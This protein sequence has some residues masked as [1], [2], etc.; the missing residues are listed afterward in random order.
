MAD[1]VLDSD[2]VIWHLRGRSAVTDLVQEL[3]G[4]ARLGVSAVTRAEVLAGARPQEETAALRFLD[5][6]ET[7]PLD[8][9]AADQAGRMVREHRARGVTLHLPDALI[10]AACLLHH[11]PLYTCN[12][13]HY[14]FPS[15]DVREVRA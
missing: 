12:A 3:A 8:A 13:R 10:A 15:L 5:A 1:V 7:L 2:V 11:V 4:R 6:C 14:P 9:P